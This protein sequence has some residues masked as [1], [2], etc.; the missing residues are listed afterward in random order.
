MIYNDFR[1]TKISS[2]A[3]GCMRLPTLGADDKID[4]EETKKMVAYAMEHGVNYYDTA[5]GY[6]M[7]NSEVVMGEVLSTYDRDKFFLASKFPGYDLANIDK[8]EEIFASQLERCKVDYFDFYLFHNVCEMNVNEYLDPKYGIYDYLIKERDA[9][10]IKH[11]GFSTHGNLDT[12]KKFLDAYGKDMEFCQLQINW[13]DWDF[14]DAKTK[15]EL[16]ASYGIPVWVMEPVRGGS[17]I[18][19]ADNYKALLKELRPNASMAEWAFRFVQSIPQV[20]VT[21]SGMTS[22][23]QLKENIELFSTQAP[24]T[25]VEK[26]TLYSIARDMTGKKSLACTK[27]RYCVEH[28]PQGLDIPWLIELYNEHVY[29]GGGFI[30]PMATSAMDSTKLPSACLGCGSCEAVCPQNISISDMMKDFSQKLQNND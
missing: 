5:W 25:E 15:V 28:C 29:S 19:L 12:M 26:E 3:L 30:A 20:V 21:L 18:N 11:L 13:V 16:V 23:D 24:L 7:G 17:L 22:I 9:G 4:V 10:R 14:Q 2:L 6:H 27:C 8:V 1:G